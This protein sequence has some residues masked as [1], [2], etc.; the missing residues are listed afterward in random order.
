MK[1][2]KLFESFCDG[3]FE[4]K[5]DSQEVIDMVKKVNDMLKNYKIMKED[6][7]KWAIRYQKD[8]LFSIAS[9]VI[10]GKLKNQDIKGKV[11]EFINKKK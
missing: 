1:H 11:E 2:I 5:K 3:V 9:S 7:K 4:S 10:S 6:R 8:P